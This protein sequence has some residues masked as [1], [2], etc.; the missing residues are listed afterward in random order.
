LHFANDL[1]QPLLSLPLLIYL[2]LPLSAAAEKSNS[3]WEPS[4]GQACTRLA[5]TAL[6]AG[7]L[8]NY[9][10]GLLLDLPVAFGISL[11]L[12]IGAGLYGL[13]RRWHRV[14]AWGWARWILVL[15]S[16]LLL[17]SPILF[18]PISE[19][20][21]RSIW[22]FHAKLVYFSGGINKANDLSQSAF[23]FSH[24]DYPM[25][26]PL[27]GAQFAA[28]SGLWNEYVPK[29]ALLPLLVLAVLGLVSASDGRIR[30][31]SIL[32]LGIFFFGSG[33][34]LNIGIVDAYL[35]IYVGVATLFLS[36][37]LQNQNQQ[38]LAAGL[39]FLGVAVNLKNEGALAVLS[40]GAVTGVFMMRTGFRS[41]SALRPLML[42]VLATATLAGWQTI[43]LRLGLENDLRLGIDSFMRAWTRLG[44]GDFSLLAAYIFGVGGIA[45]AVILLVGA[46]LLARLKFHSLPPPSVWFPAAVSTVY[47]IGMA[48]VY[49]STPDDMD[50]H[51]KYSV[52]RTMLVVLAGYWCTTYLIA[53]FLERPPVQRL[54]AA[55]GGQTRTMLVPNS[56]PA[57]GISAEHRH[58]KP[59]L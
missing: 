31:S 22:F 49:L 27:L 28:V 4:G 29:A 19:W 25:L 32:L 55:D 5:A 48:F 6:A 54:P 7:L 14:F 2:G 36:R 17:C 46:V 59:A 3:V 8:L 56:A 26:L 57:S 50:W 37:W 35:A 39:A 11:L 52:E 58:G 15:S 47:L 40:V 16:V 38:D 42:A 24:P 44:R 34:L 23:A 51:L 30:V 9:L 1:L 20:D 12:A 41:S 33:E 53:Q 43:R 45:K 21:A 13:R 18:E 10:L